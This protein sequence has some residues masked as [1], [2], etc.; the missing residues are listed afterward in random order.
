MQSF[1]QKLH[2]WLELAL[3]YLFSV[4]RPNLGAGWTNEYEIPTLW[5]CRFHRVETLGILYARIPT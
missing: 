5:E 2:M 4:L 1:L 3:K